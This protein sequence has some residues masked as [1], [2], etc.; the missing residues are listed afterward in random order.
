MKKVFAIIALMGVV[1][2][3]MTQSISAQD[4]DSAAAEQVVDTMAELTDT[5]AAEVDTA[6]TEEE[7]AA[8]AVEEGGMYKGIKTKFIEGS[9][10]WMS[11][12]AIAILRSFFQKLKKTL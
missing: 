4:A 8:P 12:V 1:T 10:A 2:F 5:M 6:A 9:V 7:V 3:G 11:P